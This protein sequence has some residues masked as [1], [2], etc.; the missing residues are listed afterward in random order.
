M[1][2]RKHW[3]FYAV[4]MVLAVALLGF[5]AQSYFRTEALISSKAFT[6]GT[7]IGVV[8]PA[9]R[10][11]SVT[12]VIQ[13]PVGRSVITVSN[14]AYVVPGGY[15]VGDR[16]PL[17][18]DQENANN[19]RVGDTTRVWVPTV[20]LII[21]GGVPALLFLLLFLHDA[22]LTVDVLVD[23][24]KGWPTAPPRPTPAV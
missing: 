5:A 23:G 11:G 7:I 9:G 4:T 2:F 14:L 8:E 19:V 3:K 15:H 13:Y 24:H 22:A 1:E 17:I 10:P 16:V 21:L 12:P 6:S 18:F 20:A